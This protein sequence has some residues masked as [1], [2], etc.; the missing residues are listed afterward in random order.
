MFRQNLLPRPH[1]QRILFAAVALLLC[2]CPALYIAAQGQDEDV[3]NVE[4]NLIVLNVTA[5]N[6]RDGYIHDLTRDDFQ[7]YEDGAPQTITTFGVEDT[8]FAAAILIDT[9][10]SMEGRV[11]LARAAAIRFLSSLRPQ[12]VAAVYRFDSKVE[13]L[14]DF[15]GSRDLATVAYAAEARGMTVLHDAISRAAQDFAGRTEKRKAILVLSDGADTQ[16]RTSQNKAL[17]Q[18]LA[19]N[20]TIYAVDMSADQSGSRSL[21]NP[22]L[23]AYAEKSGGLYVATPGGR[24]MREAF[25]AIAEELSNQYT[26]GYLTP[27]KSKDGAWRAIKVTVSRSDA[28]LRTRTG[29]KVPKK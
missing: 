28:K 27:N 20:A 11:T 18:A 9:S 4:S 7:V 17:T 25:I 5:T 24:A 29:Y 22:S 13:Q 21:P 15:S 2:F 26:I 14:Q 10:G 23:R 12:D 19:A 16:S 1:L 3:I 6:G 8:A